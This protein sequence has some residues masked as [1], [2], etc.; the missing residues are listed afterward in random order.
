MSENRVMRNLG[1]RRRKLHN[2]L[3]N[4]YSPINI[5]RMIGAGKM[6]WARHAAYEGKLK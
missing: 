6:R 5:I 4:F 3:R 1:L 2:G